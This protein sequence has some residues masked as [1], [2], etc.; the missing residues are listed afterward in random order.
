MCHGQGKEATI[1]IAMECARMWPILLWQIS[2]HFNINVMVVM[3]GGASFRVRSNPLHSSFHVMVG[4]S[5]LNQFSIFKAQVK[6]HQPKP[7]RDPA[8]G[9]PSAQKASPSVS[10]LEMRL[11]QLRMQAD[12]NDKTPV[13]PVAESSSGSGSMLADNFFDG[14]DAR[15]GGRG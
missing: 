14:A 6:P 15:A 12:Q 8:E 2:F 11:R 3:P 13:P 4:V 7:R 1:K 5:G 9:H 10:S